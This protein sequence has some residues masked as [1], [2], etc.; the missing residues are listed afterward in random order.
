LSDAN[1]IINNY[2][3][4]LLIKIEV[5]VSFSMQ[6]MGLRDVVVVVNNIVLLF[7]FD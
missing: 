7:Y 1:T 3:C 6:R 5:D 2:I 4:F